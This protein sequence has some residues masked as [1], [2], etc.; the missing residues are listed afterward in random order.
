MERP[1][2]VPPG[3]RYEWAL[4]ADWCAAAETVPLPAS[5]ET[6][7]AFLDDNPAGDETLRRRV[8]AINRAHRNA[9]ESEPGTVTAIRLRLDRAR[10]HRVARRRIAAASIVPALPTIGWPAGLF[11]RRDALVLVLY[12][13]GLGPRD[14][15]ALDRRD[16]EACGDGLRIHGRHQLDTTELSEVD[17]GASAR[18]WTLWQQVLDV[19]DRSASTRV[20]EDL[21]RTG[22]VPVPY[23]GAAA[24]RGPVVVPIDRWGAVPFPLTA[25]SAPSVAAVIAAHL[26]G[27][28]PR[29]PTRPERVSRGGDARTA[30]PGTE[31]Y[32]APRLDHGYY[33]AG[34]AARRDAAVAMTEV[35]DIFDD[36]DIRTEQL[37]RCTMDLL[38]TFQTL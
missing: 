25:M 26:N 2:Q 28:A 35:D 3:Y 27:T 24:R 11:G 21:L 14:I 16:I 32:E 9:G 34:T 18:T 4:F 22:H 38:E 20:L 7:A 37:L 6:L 10:S 5:P 12:A 29:H 17:S 15:A 19:A 8:A 1:H 31:H 13:L 33:D 36:I 23:V 30:P